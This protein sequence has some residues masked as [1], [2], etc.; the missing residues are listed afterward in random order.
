MIAL[1]EFIDEPGLYTINILHNL[2]NL[3]ETP[4]KFAYLPE[5]NL[6]GPEPN[7]CYSPEHP[8]VIEILGIPGNRI[9]IPENQKVKRE[10]KYLGTRLVMREM[11]EP[12]IRFSLQWA[13]N[14]IQICYEIE[15]VTAWVEG[16]GDKLIVIEN[17]T[18]QL[19]IHARGKPNERYNLQVNN[20]HFDRDF[21]LNAKGKSDEY[22]EKTALRDILRISKFINT[23][24][25]IKIRGQSWRLFT[26]VKFP[27][28]DIKEVQY[29]K[30]KI[31]ITLEQENPL[32]GNYKLQVKN[33]T[34]L[35]QQ[36]DLGLENNLQKKHDY[37]IALEPGEYT[38]EILCQNEVV[39]K[40]AIF[41]V[42]RKENQVSISGTEN[43]RIPISYKYTAAEIY[44]SLSASPQAY[45]SFADH[46]SEDLLPII[47]Q[48]KLVNDFNTW[49]NPNGKLDEN[50]KIL[51]PTWAVINHPLRV[52]TEK[53]RK[54]MHLFPQK[55]AYGGK[56]GKGFIKAKFIDGPIN[57]YAAWKTN[58]KSNQTFL[59]VMV[60]QR[61]NITRF[62][63]LD[64][65]DL[66]PGYLCV[67]CGVIVGSKDGTRLKLPPKTISLHAH[68][69][70]SPLNQQFIDIVY[71]KNIQANISYFYDEIL[72]QIDNPSSI[73]DLNFSHDR[74]DGRTDKN[75]SEIEKPINPNSSNAYRNAYSE[76]HRNYSEIIHSMNLKQIIGKQNLFTSLE[77]EFGILSSDFIAFRAFFRLYKCFKITRPLSLLPKYILILAMLL[78]Y[79]A[80]FPQE[81]KFAI[82][83]TKT[84]ENEI[85][86]TTYFA[87]LS[88]PKLLE[89]SIYWAEVFFHHAPFREF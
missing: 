70:H 74:F 51:L 62:C 82:H 56:F 50:F 13:G 63:D 58:L 23:E 27:K 25:W 87:M 26:Y 15:R 52:V 10:E 60:P 79:K 61:E 22:I 68:K 73:V 48:L 35:Q 5:I 24:I 20:S 31:S 9:V 17:Q 38:L 69:K 6:K 28:I 67:D 47:E 89:W 77:Y 83:H 39:A 72:D 4:L 8:A 81:Y 66:W 57:L 75:P 45:F 88:C 14:N 59:W 85:A 43:I 1:S 18:N 76:L 37:E 54:I 44:A 40:S 7:K 19:V 64:E 11:R 49:I 12:D 46:K 71:E 33:E 36:F 34:N 80:H 2:H 78:R 55:V 21:Y 30:N 86:E 29:K 32:Y 53:H 3:L 65:Y 42:F 84:E 16:A 41:K